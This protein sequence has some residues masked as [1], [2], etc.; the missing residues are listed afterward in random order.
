MCASVSST[1]TPSTHVT[2]HLKAVPHKSCAPR[3]Q[4]LLA[5]TA[6]AKRRLER[7][8]AEHERARA[9]FLKLTKEGF[10]DGGAFHRSAPLPLNFMENT[11]GYF[12]LNPAAIIHYPDG[13]AM[14]V[15]LFDVLF[16]TDQGQRLRKWRVA[17]FCCVGS[18]RSS[19]TG[20]A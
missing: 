8:S 18:L 1:G 13:V 20:L 5:R 12:E 19:D 3:S 2:I 17:A 7:C 4:V 16:G 6:E 9:H 10:F 11:L 15:G 14:M